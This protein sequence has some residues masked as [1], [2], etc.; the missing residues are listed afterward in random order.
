MKTFLREHFWARCFAALVLVILLP[1]WL[2]AILIV[3]ILIAA[4]GSLEEIIK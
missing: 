1:V 3:V 2:P 4:Y